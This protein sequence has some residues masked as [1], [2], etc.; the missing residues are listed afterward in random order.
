M[1]G[2]LQEIDI[3][4]ILQL[5]ELGQRTGELF[6]EASPSAYWFVFFLNGRIIYASDTEGNITRLRDYLHRFKV[7]AALDQIQIPHKAAVNAPEYNRLWA[8]LEN[9]KLNPNQGKQILLSMVREVLFDLLSLHHG[10]FIFE[11][12]SPLAPQLTTFPV[13]P[14]LTEIV[15]QVQEWKK[16][17]PYIQTPNQA[18]TILNPTPLQ[19]NL[20]APVFKAL[21]EW[22]NGK[23]SIRQMG[24]YLGRDTLTVAKAIYP[25]VRQGAIQL[26]EPILIAEPKPS[27]PLSLSGKPSHILCID[28]SMAIQ[29]N[30]EFILQNEGYQVTTIGNPLKALGQVFLLNPDMI[31]CDVAMPKLDGYEL[32]AMLRKSSQFRQTPMIMLTGKDGFTDRIKAR[33]AGAN[34][35]LSKPFSEKELLTIVESYVGPPPKR[36]PSE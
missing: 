8:L 7:E 35:F 15:T 22:S 17:Y 16:L 21:S 2:K 26:S 11:A 13:T 25:Y 14:L 20:P 9:H 28:D 6:V 30:V 3:R 19:Q 4:S 33:M 5:I 32:C 31:L 18:P 36:G 10:S 23:T 29:K 12:G 24:R 34:E 1:Q 27:R